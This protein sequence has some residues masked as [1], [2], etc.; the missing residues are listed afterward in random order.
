MILSELWAVSFLERET[1]VSHVLLAGN[2]YFL[3]KT[4][5]RPHEV[6]KVWSN[7]KKSTN[8]GPHKVLV[9]NNFTIFDWS[10]PHWNSQKLTLF[11]KRIILFLIIIRYTITSKYRNRWR[12]FHFNSILS[13]L[14]IYN[15]RDIYLVSLF[16][17]SCCY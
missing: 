2:A 9:Y 4:S 6:N 13:Y 8:N 16:I 1:Y 5:L 7:M 17:W 3:Q 15:T 10:F 11:I 12:G 14:Y